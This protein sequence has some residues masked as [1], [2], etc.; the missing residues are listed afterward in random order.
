M[1]MLTI[2]VSTEEIRTLTILENHRFTRLTLTLGSPQTRFAGILASQAG[3]QT[4][5]EGQGTQFAARHISNRKSDDASQSFPKD[6]PTAPVH[7]TATLGYKAGMTTTVRE[8]ERP[9][10]KMHKKE[11]VEAVTVI[12]TPPVGYPLDL[13]IGICG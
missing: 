10:A 2:C 4:Q 11:I 13:E 12:E 5:R 9:G 7:L 3:L 8:L 1:E 6:D